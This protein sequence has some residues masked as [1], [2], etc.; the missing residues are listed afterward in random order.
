[1]PKHGHDERMLATGRTLD[2]RGVSRRKLVKSAAGFAAAPVLLKYAGQSVGA[3]EEIP[4]EKS[5]ATI[6]GKLRILLKTDFHPDYNAF[7]DQELKAY[8]EV[9][10]WDIEVS[11][12]AGYA[13]GSDLYQKLQGQV[14][15][16][17]A[18]DLLIHDIDVR[19]LH[20]LGLIQ[21]VSD[22]VAEAVEAFGE[23][24]PGFVFDANFDDEWWAV[25]FFTRAGGYYVRQDIFEEHGLDVIADM[26]Y[27]D[28]MREAALAVTNADENQWGWGMT[29]NRSG[30]GNS[31]VQNVIF[32]FG[33]HLQDE[34]GEI[35]TF[36][37]PETIAG[38]EWLAATYTEEQYQ[39][40]LPPG[41]LS[42]TDTSNNEAFIS[43]QIVITQNAGT[44]YAKAVFDQVPFADQIAYIPVPRR[45]SDDQR[46]DFLSGMKF[47]LITD[48]KNKDAS[49]D[50]IRHFLTEPVKQEVWRISRAYALPAYRVGWENPVITENANSMQGKEIA[51]NPGGFTGLSWPG[52]DTAAVSSIAAGTFFTDMMSE[53]IQGRSADEV[54]GEYHDRF[55]QVYQD[56]GFKGE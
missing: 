41:I 29:V 22:M 24:V 50:L 38:L 18:P 30:D 12:V 39:P 52:P 35:V 17:D 48:A 5:S 2:R 51:L 42:W 54:V 7:M 43:G 9:N 26:E 31:L 32:R 33:G 37:S 49:Y 10:G 23:P 40:M 11:D 53:I 20:T 8:A 45:L 44:M 21:P 55:V 16:G 14:G 56:F 19:N 46:L 47:H 13:A 36:N 27:Y 1:M 34:A 6:D 4:R 3:Q 25:P 15:A 28:K